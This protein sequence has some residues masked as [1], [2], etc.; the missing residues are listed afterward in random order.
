MPDAVFVAP[1]NVGKGVFANRELSRCEFV[2]QVTGRVIPD[3]EYSSEYC[4]GLDED[5][6][7][8]PEAPFRFLN[9]SCDPNCELYVVEEV[10]EETGT[11]RT[12]VTVETVRELVE[13]EELLIDYGWPADHAIECY[14]GSSICRGWIVDPA[15]LHLVTQSTETAV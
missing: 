8:E 13:G 9:H 6:S 12:I 5:S 14:C 7:L 10:C 3:D 1:A 11:S 4:I 2:G 15:E